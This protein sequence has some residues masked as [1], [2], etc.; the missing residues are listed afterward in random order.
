MRAR[1]GLMPPERRIGQTA[2]DFVQALGTHDVVITRAQK[3]DGSPMVPSRFL[4]RL[5][6]FTGRRS[7]RA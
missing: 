6:A 3:R 1:V 4:Q 5:K 7:G 2:H